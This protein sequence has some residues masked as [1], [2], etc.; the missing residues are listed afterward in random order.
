MKKVLFFAAA[1]L[2]LGTMVNAQTNIQEMYDFNREHLTTTLEGFYA[3]DWGST[4]FFTDIYHPTKANE[5]TP[6][7]YYTEI[8]RGLNFWKNTA[9]APLS[10]HVEWNGGQFASNAW[11]F[12]V[13]YF[14]HSDD[15]RNTF[16]FELMYKNIQK[17]EKNTPVQFTFVWGMKDLFG[18]KGLSFSG[19]LDVWGEKA[20]W[21][22]N[23]GKAEETDW[24]V[25]S[26]PQIWYNIGQH[27]GCPNLNIGGEVEVAYNFAGGWQSG[28]NFYKNKGLNVAPCFGIKWV[29]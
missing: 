15:F 28:N 2:G 6:T 14:L 10:L 17:A 20:S 7:G 9:L 19:F 26:E 3:D 25:L 21:V 11:L 5:I 13:E 27:F 24:V 1:L 12:G 22:D 23:N 16:T 4:F 8:A 29:F 18:V